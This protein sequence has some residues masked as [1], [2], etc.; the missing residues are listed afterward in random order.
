MEYR[1]F[2]RTGLE[3]SEIGFGAW[4]IGGKGWG[5]DVVDDASRKALQAAWELGMN[6]FD[7]ADAYGDGHSE[8]LIGEFLQGKREQAVIV[9]KGGTNFRLPERSKDFTH[10]YLM[11]CL[12]ESL[13]RLKTDYVDCYLLHV[14]SS[15]WQ[16]RERVLETM[17]EMKASGKTRFVGLAMWGATDTLHALKQ[18]TERVIDVLE[19]PFNILNKSNPEV[20]AIA[21]E[22]DIA[23]MT[24]QP[25]ASGI[26]TGKYQAGTAFANGDHRKGFWSAERWESVEQSLATI[27]QCADEA[28]MSMTQLALAYNLSWPGISCV[29]P[30][31]K[32]AAQVELNAAASGL[33]ISEELRKKLDAVPGF[34]Y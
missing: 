11:M 29:I 22:R 15:E 10:D 13:R 18:D 17:K 14:P 32:N 3:V 5:D 21:K 19:V 34:V 27:K 9:T 12:D 2:G 33:R 7:T 26:L 25:L 24:S 28:N 31:G 30:G 6:L 16:D 1:T 8:V 4:A 20:V 23:V